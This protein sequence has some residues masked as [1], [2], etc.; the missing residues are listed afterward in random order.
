MDEHRAPGAVAVRLL[1]RRDRLDKQIGGRFAVGV[2]DDLD[3]VGERPVDGVENLF[4]R[5]GRVAGVVVCIIADGIVVG[6]VAPRGEALRR[7]VDG[8][9]GAADAKMVLVVGADVRRDELAVHENVRVGHDID[10]EAAVGGDLAHRLDG[11]GH[12]A[13]FLR[14]RVAVARPERRALA[15]EGQSGL[16][17]EAA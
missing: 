15:G 6:A 2:G 5:G 17:A 4:A 1:G 3:V 10:L 13:A 16:L 14:G 7:A 9:L 12:R 11:G 8:Q